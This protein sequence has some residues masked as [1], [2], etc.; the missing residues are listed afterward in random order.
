MVVRVRVSE[1]FYSLQGEAK[2]VGQ[3]TTFIRLTG[4]PLRCHYCDTAYAFQG[5][6][7]KTLDDIVDK[8]KTYPTKLVT[9]TGGE[10]LAQPDCLPLLRLL[11]QEGYR[12]SLETSGALPI[13]S[14]P[15]AVSIVLDLKTPGSGEVH[16]NLYENIAELRS[17]DQIKFVILD[18]A[19][20]DW[21]RFKIS[22]FDLTARVKEV[23]F[24]PVYESLKPVQLA[25][26]ILED[27]LEVRLQVQL[28]K[29]LW[30]DK[31]GV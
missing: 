29:L 3:P 22:E 16:R 17:K 23:L 24:S 19:D 4:C 12:V 13:A 7:L 28:H 30:G 26:W 14:V 21:A 11:I 15:D 5:G 10:P 31:P 8:V 20:Y 18:K 1:I 2:T 6:E 25:E 27:G 9:V